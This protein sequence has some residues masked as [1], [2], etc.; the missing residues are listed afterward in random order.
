VKT[1]VYLRVSSK[2]QDLRSQEPDLKRWAK[3][4]TE[5]GAAIEWYSDTATGTSMDRPG[6]NRLWRAVLVGE[7]KRIVVWRLDRLGRTPKETI[8][9][10]A[11]MQAR[12]VTLI[13]LKDSFDLSS[14]SGRL[15][16][17]I[18]ASFAGYETEVRG[19]RQRAGI[20]AARTK[21]LVYPGRKPGTPK[22]QPARAAE[23]RAAGM[24]VREVAGA[25]GISAATVHRYLA[26]AAPAAD[27]PP[28]AGQA[29]GGAR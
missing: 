6:W 22:A 8:P 23:L 15:F 19:E 11:D 7:V 26:Q 18:L 2:S 5:A 9:L 4:E 10:F 13:S 20:D 27:V 3:G 17:N 1:A 29:G 12:G 24:K 14:A 28:P 21:G 25:M 16:A